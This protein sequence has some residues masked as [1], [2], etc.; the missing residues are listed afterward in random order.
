M[1]FYEFIQDFRKDRDKSICQLSALPTPLIRRSS[2]V[3]GRLSV[4]GKNTGI[5]L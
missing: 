4:P 1:K 2:V 5:D 3:I